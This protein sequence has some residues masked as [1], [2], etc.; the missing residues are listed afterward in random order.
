MGPG[1]PW[2]QAP[3]WLF[4]QDFLPDESLEYKQIKP[5]M[6]GVDLSQ[7]RIDLRVRFSGDPFRNDLHAPIGE[8]IQAVF[9]FR[10][11]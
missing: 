6:S 4:L 8:G 9:N 11:R 1:H 7:F 10:L 3:D 2:N 5:S